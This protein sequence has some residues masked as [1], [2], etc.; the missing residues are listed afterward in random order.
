MPL[1]SMGYCPVFLAAV[2]VALVISS[3]DYCPV[4]LAAI[5]VALVMRDA[6]AIPAPTYTHMMSEWI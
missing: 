5:A 2:A 4:V 1:S 6:A 3:L